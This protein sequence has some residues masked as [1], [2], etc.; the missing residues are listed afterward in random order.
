ML[1]KEQYEQIAERLTDYG[2]PRREA[3][4][5][6]LNQAREQLEQARRQLSKNQ[7]EPTQL[8]LQAA[9]LALRQVQRYLGSKL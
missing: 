2:G 1:C 7:I 8:S 4:Q 6:L 9:Q 5:S 3:A